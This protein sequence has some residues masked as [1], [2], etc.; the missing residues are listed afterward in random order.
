VPARRL[1]FAHHHAFGSGTGDSAFI[2]LKNL[3]NHRIFH[4]LMYWSKRPTPCYTAAVFQSVDA[5]GT[6]GGADVFA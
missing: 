2:P 1:G 5:S 3:Q 6:V 4:V